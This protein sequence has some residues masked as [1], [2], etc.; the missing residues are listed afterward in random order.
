M[1]I[2]DIDANGVFCGRLYVYDCELDNEGQLVF[3]SGVYQWNDGSF[4]DEMEPEVDP[5]AIFKPPS[6]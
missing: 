3:Y 1:A 6:K 2:L 5:L 4:H